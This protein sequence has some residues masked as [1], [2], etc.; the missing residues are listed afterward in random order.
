[1]MM[2]TAVLDAVKRKGYLKLRER[3]LGKFVRSALWI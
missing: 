3:T 2:Q 1:M